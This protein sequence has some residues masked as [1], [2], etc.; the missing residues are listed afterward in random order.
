MVDEEYEH[1]AGDVIEN[2]LNWRAVTRKDLN[3]IFSCQAS[4]TI[5]SEPRETSVVLY[6][7]C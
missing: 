2:R 6:L 5:L 3:S 1:N 4:N 7:N